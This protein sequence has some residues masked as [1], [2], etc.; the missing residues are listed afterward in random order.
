MKTI[1]TILFALAVAAPLACW[2]CGSGTE[3]PLPGA[4]GSD[5]DDDDDHSGARWTGATQVRVI[6]PDGTPVEGAFALQ[7]GA[8]EEDWV[9][10]DDEG[11]ATLGVTDDG[12][13]DRWLLADKEGYVAG[14]VDLD[15]EVGPVG[16]QDIVIYPLPAPDADN[17]DYTF[18]PG[19]DGSA[20]DTEFCGHCHRTIA[21]D[22]VDARHRGSASNPN[23]WD[24]YVGGIDADAEACAARGGWI[25][26]GQEPGVAGGT[27]QRCYLGEG[28]LPFL[29]DTCGEPGQS[30]C[31]HPD[32]AAE[33][34]TFGSCGDCHVPAFEGVEPGEIDFARSVGVAHDDGVACDLCH[35]V[36]SV[37]VGPAPGREALALQRP[38]EPTKIF[39]Q[40]FDPITF[41]PYPDV[42][43]GIMKGAYSPQFRDAGWCSACHQY[44][45]DALH[46]DQGVDPERWP[47]GLPILETYAEYLAS[48]YEATPDTCQSCHM[49][50]LDE[51]SSTYDLT[52]QGLIPSVSQGWLRALGEVRHHD[53]AATEADGAGIQMTVELDGD[54]VVATVT[55]RNQ[56]AGHALPTG[57]PMRQ[58][59][60]RITATDADGLDVLASGGQAIPED[61]GW[62]VR[63]ELGLDADLLD[64]TLTLPG[65]ELTGVELA[66][67]VR[68]T[69][70][71]DDYDGP[72]TGSF[73]GLSAEEKGLPLY[74]VIAQRAVL[75]IDGDAAELDAD[76]PDLQPGDLVYLGGPDDT[77]GAPGWLYGKTFLDAD[78]ER[79]VPH[80]RAVDV[81]VDN[82]VAAGER[83]VSTHRFPAPQSGELT[84]TAT[85]VYRRH[86]ASIASFYGWEVDD[87]ELVTQDVVYSAE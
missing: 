50:E 58:F 62:R 86:R 9:V 38:S 28:V 49:A 24:V 65:Q 64:T 73:D 5:D 11:L 42:P 85:L 51:E 31:D 10:T 30:A 74:D 43:I 59:I 22:W 68:P 78:G 3:R 33:L 17:R 36:R 34:D 41:G 57:A 18:Q 55:V 76:V 27:R 81:T 20:E 40:D 16:I 60:V 7:G 12:V 14:G 46:P 63:G 79:G 66:R 61:G 15:D 26:A 2:G 69:G 72:G 13:T 19:G 71:W 52:T 37:D 83:G 6:D 21:D 54:E 56:H 87:E 84:V 39:G 23:V 53:L 45:R 47:D 77:A 29:H 82:R 75:S 44:A 32:G 35:K 25:D 4:S 1:E 70:V 8:L 67:F 80:Y 48:A